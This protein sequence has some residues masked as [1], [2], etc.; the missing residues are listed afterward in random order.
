MGA[1][2]GPLPCVQNIY[3]PTYTSKVIVAFGSPTYSSYYCFSISVKCVYVLDVVCVHACVLCVCL[4]D[5]TFLSLSTF[6]F[7]CSLSRNVVLKN[8]GRMGLSFLPD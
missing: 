7:D 5:T 1:H 6:P 8:V 3:S 4:F 2:L